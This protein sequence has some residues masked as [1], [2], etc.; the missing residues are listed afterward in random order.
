MFTCSTQN[1]CSSVWRFIKGSIGAF[2]AAGFDHDEGKA[3]E[4]RQQ[5]RNSEALRKTLRERDE[6][7]GAYPMAI[8]KVL[9]NYSTQLFHSAMQISTTVMI[10]ESQSKS[11]RW[12]SG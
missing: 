7:G 6:V 9:H 3:I 8:C 5:R 12:L 11:L 1:L 10:R 4:R 2:D